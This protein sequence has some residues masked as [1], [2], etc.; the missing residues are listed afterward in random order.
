MKQKS[1]YRLCKNDIILGACL[2]AAAVILFAALAMAKSGG[3]G[4]TVRITV[5]GSVWAQYPLDEDRTV[6][7]SEES[8]VNV[9]EI[10]QG[11]V[12]MKEADC[13]DE[14]CVLKGSISRTGETIVCLP[15]RLVAEIYSETLKNEE[16]D[17]IAE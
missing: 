7:V 15:H 3:D 14:Y 13:P 16:F 8:G 1:Q 17:A 12:R 2:A 5:G 10:K 4:N 11:T 9:I 6:T